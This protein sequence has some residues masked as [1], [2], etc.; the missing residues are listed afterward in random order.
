MES[1]ETASRLAEYLP[2]AVADFFELFL[3]NL[4]PRLPPDLVRQARG[5]EI[6][7]RCSERRTSKVIYHIDNDEELRRIT[8]EIRPPL[9]GSILCLG[10]ASGMVGGETLF[11]MGTGPKPPRLT[12]EMFMLASWRKVLA[13]VAAP[14]IVPQRAGRLT[15]F[16]GHL[17]HAAAPIRRLPASQ[18]RVT[19]LA[20]LW[21]RRLVSVPRGICAMSPA[22]FREYLQR[23]TELRKKSGRAGRSPRAPSG[24]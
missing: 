6:W 3:E 24:L 11:E 9:M 18:P 16:S 13:H 14:L 23:R 21:Q 2:S 10:P 19:V 7:N 8:G 15:L 1:G 20:N 22:G 17:P 12:R 4:A 5:F